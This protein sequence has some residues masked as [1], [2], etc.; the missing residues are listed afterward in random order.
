VAVNTA[1]T[2]V[3]D[4]MGWVKG[5][6][7]PLNA[8]VQFEKVYPALGV[9]VNVIDVPEEAVVTLGFHVMVPPVA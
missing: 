2:V 8:P 3:F 4:V 6:V 1:L 5:L 7:V 9:A